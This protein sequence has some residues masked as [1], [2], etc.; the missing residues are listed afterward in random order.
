MGVNGGPKGGGMIFGGGL[1]F[2]GLAKGFGL[3]PSELL[4]VTPVEG[5]AESSSIL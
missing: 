1:G 4:S 5:D 3:F 2:G